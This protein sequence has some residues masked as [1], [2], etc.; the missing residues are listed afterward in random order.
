MSKNGNKKKRV[1]AIIGMII[2]IIVLLGIAALLFVQGRMS[3]ISRDTNV[4]T[5]AVA[6]SQQTFEVD[7][8][9]G[10]DTIKPEEI[11]W[12]KP[13][14]TPTPAVEEKQETTTAKARGVKNLLLIGQDARM[15][16]GRQRSDTMVIASINAD[17]GKIT[18]C[19]LMRDMYVPIPGYADNRINAAYVFG[20]MPLLDQ[21]IDEDFG[22]HIDGN[23]EVDLDGF[24]NS[25]EAI[26]PL[27]IELNEE[28]AAYLNE[29][30]ALGNNI[31]NVPTQN[32]DLTPGLNSLT[33]QQALAYS[34]IRGV[35][36]ADYERTERQRRVLT[37]AFNKLVDSDVKVLLN[38]SGSLLPNFTTDLSQTELLDYVSMI[39]EN[40]ITLNNESYR[41][42]VDG[43]YSSESVRGMSVLVPDLQANSELLHEYLYS[44]NAGAAV[45]APAA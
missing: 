37:A 45:T 29:N 3:K 32:W 23:I 1:G 16:E 8:N 43:T 10:P 25:M 11:K 30:P 42:P 5:D 41:I 35:G 44:S 39:K 24:L 2:A 19:S 27:E 18:M 9:A 13:T 14:A 36:H 34:R 31:D 17:T 21:V 15:G 28:E 6:P 40:G 20:G 33:P 4:V 38:L 7:E 26:G 22:V 12:T